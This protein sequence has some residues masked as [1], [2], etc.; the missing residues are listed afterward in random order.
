MLMAFDALE[1]QGYTVEK[2]YMS[3]SALI[4][5]ALAR[6]DADL[7]ML[8]NQTMWIAITKGAQ[9]R[10]I[11]QFTAPA[12][13]LAAKREIAS[14]SDLDNKKIAVA[15]TRGLSPALLDLY[16][17]QKCSGVTPQFLVILESTGR[18][19]ALMSGE[20]DA[21]VLPQEELLKLQRETPDRFHV[22]MSP[23]EEFPDIQ[24]D[25]LHIRRQWAEQNPQLIKDFLRALLN[26]YRQIKAN[27][28]LLFDESVKR[29]SIDPESAKA[30][31]EA[32]LRAGIWDSNGGL[33]QQNI[34]HTIDF[35]T[36]IDALPKGLK[37]EDVADLS[38]LKSVLDEI[39]RQ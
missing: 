9:V 15:T 30:I 3:S 17:K 18:A 31:G 37:V 14:C 39:G 5:D 33:T 4:A 7:G 2:T 16:L 11:A 38:Y 13:V 32:H 20:V 1:T 28:H 10:T 8:N 29:L 23:A 26:A 35:L 12:T 22:I 24:I 36:N 34:Q 25:G 6:G 27:P 19:A 21:T